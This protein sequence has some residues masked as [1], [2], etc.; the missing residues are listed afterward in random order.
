M[1][2]AGSARHPLWGSR[3]SNVNVGLRR[4]LEDLVETSHHPLRIAAAIITLVAVV[5]VGRVLLGFPPLPGFCP[6]R[7]QRLSLKILFLFLLLF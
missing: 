7:L 2:V 1:A 4:A 6:T 3:P 5:L